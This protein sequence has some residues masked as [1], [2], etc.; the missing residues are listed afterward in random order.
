M[1]LIATKS[2]F[3]YVPF[4]MNDELCVKQIGSSKQEYTVFIRSYSVL[5]SI[6][7]KIG[8]DLIF[9]SSLNWEIQNYLNKST[10]SMV[11][12]LNLFFTL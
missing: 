8:Y 11:K 9:K 7:K 10:F 1:K 2:L 5:I 4:S 6:M 12:L 3:F